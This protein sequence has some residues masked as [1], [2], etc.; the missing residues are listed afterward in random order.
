MSKIHTARKIRKPRESLVNHSRNQGSG[1]YELDFAS[2]A[3]L[4][5]SSCPSLLFKATYFYHTPFQ[6][7]ITETQI[8]PSG[9]WRAVDMDACSMSKQKPRKWGMNCQTPEKPLILQCI[10]GLNQ[11]SLPV[12]LCSMLRATQN[13]YNR[14][15]C[16]LHHCGQEQSTGEKSDS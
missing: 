13:Q 5:F 11:L 4:F 14:I 10:A 16:R 6:G 7:L 12:C 15:N 3:C 8:G 9:C 1:F 2:F